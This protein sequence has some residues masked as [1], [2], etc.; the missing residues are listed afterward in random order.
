M[1]QP[2]SAVTRNDPGE[3]LMLRRY[4]L[5]AR[6]TALVGCALPD[7]VWLYSLATAGKDRL[8]LDRTPMM[9]AFGS[10]DLFRMLQAG[11]TAGGHGLRS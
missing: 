7:T 6:M 1:P 5:L 10:V 8:G 2:I 4:M 3:D 11:W 9:Q